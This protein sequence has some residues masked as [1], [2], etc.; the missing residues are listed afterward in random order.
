MRNCKINLKYFGVIKIIRIFVV[1]LRTTA[2]E[3]SETLERE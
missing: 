3:E 2:A 1:P